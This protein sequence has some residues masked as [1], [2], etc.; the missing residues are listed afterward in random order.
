[1][2]NT[3]ISHLLG[4]KLKKGPA[5][6]LYKVSAIKFIRTIAKEISLIEQ[7][8]LI[9]IYLYNLRIPE[10]QI[11]IWSIIIE[12]INEMKNNEVSL[13][14]L[15]YGFNEIRNSIKFLHKYNPELQDAMFDFLY[16][17]LIYFNQIELFD[18]TKKINI[19][20]FVLN[21]I[22]PKNNKNS[23]YE[24]DCYLRLLGKSY[25]TLVFLNKHEETIDLDCTND[26]YTSFCDNLWI[27]SLNEDFRKSVFEIMQDLFLACYE[28]EE[29]RCEF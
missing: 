19:C 4:E 12:I 26:V 1:M 2:L 6:E 18:F 24:R 25:V 11:T 22:R 16:N 21:E 13:L 8:I 17:S 23:Y 3:V 15:N 29:Y 28:R 14:L 10:M 20:K 9:K 5:Q 7:S 27:T